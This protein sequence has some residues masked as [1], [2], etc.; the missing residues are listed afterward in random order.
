M[1]RRQQA[2]FRS[3]RWEELA[4]VPSKAIARPTRFERVTSTFGG[5]RSIQ[6]SYGRICLR[7]AYADFLRVR[8]DIHRSSKSLFSRLLS[9]CPSAQTGLTLAIGGQRSCR[10]R[11]CC[12]AIGP[13][14]RVLAKGETWR[15]HCHRCQGL[16]LPDRA[17]WYLLGRLAH[18]APWHDVEPPHRY[19]RRLGITYRWRCL[20]RTVRWGYGR[21]SP[22]TVPRESRT[23]CDWPSRR[24]RWQQRQIAYVHSIT[25]STCRGT[26]GTTAAR[27][28][29]SKAVEMYL[30]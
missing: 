29:S 11:I 8:S 7:S 6:L 25:V 23:N 14:R 18:P 10:L 12:S 22:N 26:S 30:A 13:P 19:C 5:W 2:P 16:R 1:T 28:R 17:R 24:V 15:R 21:A 3:S 27:A 9:I 20:R 4:R